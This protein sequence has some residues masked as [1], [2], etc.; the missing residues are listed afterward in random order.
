MTDYL[1]MIIILLAGIFAML[2]YVSLRIINHNKDVSEQ[3]DHLYNMI[4]NW[5]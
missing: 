2:S 3:L 5:H 1:M 4:A